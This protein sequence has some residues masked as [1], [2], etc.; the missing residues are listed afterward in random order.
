[1]VGE[2]GRLMN[3]INRWRAQLAPNPAKIGS[4][5][6]VK[7]LSVVQCSQ[8]ARGVKG[9]RESVRIAVLNGVC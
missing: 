7:E 2:E 1:M 5:Q 4:A 8:P 6:R 9:P 3:W